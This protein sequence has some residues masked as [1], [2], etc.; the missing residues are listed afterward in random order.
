M[1]G[2]ESC[3]AKHVGAILERLIKCLHDDGSGITYSVGSVYSIE[4]GH[5]AWVNGHTTA[6][7]HEFHGMWGQNG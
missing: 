4:Q 3:Q 2:M 5:D 6:V 7:A 1:V